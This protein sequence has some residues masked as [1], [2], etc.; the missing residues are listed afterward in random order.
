MG[1]FQVLY[2]FLLTYLSHKL[3]EVKVIISSILEMK[4]LRLQDFKQVEWE[5]LNLCASNL[6]YTA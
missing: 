5:I 2:L 4:K 6:C 1:I 3:Y